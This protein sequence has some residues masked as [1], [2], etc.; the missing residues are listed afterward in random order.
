M[1]GVV[2][3]PLLVLG[4]GAVG[5]AVEEGDV[6]LDRLVHVERQVGLV[7]V[8]PVRNLGARFNIYFVG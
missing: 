6:E 4:G 5:V 8:R 2:E 1:D 3:R 7:E